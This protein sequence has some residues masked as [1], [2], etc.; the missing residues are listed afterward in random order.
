MTAN[1]KV[2]K[3]KHRDWS[4]YAIIICLIL[5]AIPA[6]W[7]LWQI[8]PASMRSGT[9]VIGSRFEGDL[10]P[11]ISEESLTAVKEGIAQLENAEG[12]EL[13]LVTGTVRIFIS[14]G[15]MVDE[16]RMNA[17]VQE[18]YTVLTAELPVETYFTTVDTKQMYDIEI[19]VY[20]RLVEEGEEQP[21]IYV[22]GNKSAIRADLRIQ[23][24]TTPVSQEL[25]DLFHQIQDARDNPPPA[26]ENEE[27]S[28]SDGSTQGA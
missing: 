14:T 10:D 5:L 8:I 28:Q 15:D 21:F 25:V 1:K 6:T 24:L 11:A 2:K 3:N 17:L 20:S 9:P 22:M 7:L 13:H 26:V 12:V 18:A 19:N 27:P 23:T 16:A 4:F